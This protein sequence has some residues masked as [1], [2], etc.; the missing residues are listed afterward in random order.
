MTV[1][2]FIFNP[3][4]ENTYVVFDETLQAAVIDAGCLSDSEKTQLR[5]FIEQNNLSIQ[6]VINTHLH[7]DHQFGNRF[8][9]QTYNIA[10]QAGIEDEFLLQNIAAQMRYFGLL[11]NEE[12]QMLGAYI[13]DNQIIKFGNSELKAIHVPGH[14]PG[15]MAFYSAKDGIL[16]SGDVLFNGSIGRSDLQ[17]G[18]FATLINSIKQ[19][20]LCLPDST[21]VYCGHGRNTT[22]GEEK[23]SNSFLLAN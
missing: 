11:C 1:K 17:K 23:R 9:F 16:F 2:S 19:R 13:A 15:S 7:L 10:P 20:L 3:F 22:I 12:A 4:Q 6:Q 18:D 14:S 8:L 21:L 5:S